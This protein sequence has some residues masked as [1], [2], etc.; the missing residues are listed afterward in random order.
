MKITKSQLE[1]IIKE[2]LKEGIFGSSPSRDRKLGPRS[3]SDR[4]HATGPL[5]TKKHAELILALL[6]NL[7]DDIMGFADVETRQRLLPGLYRT[8][9]SLRDWI[10]ELDKEQY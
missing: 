8:R 9:T 1:K 7:Y 3:L 2:E 10:Q 6:E 4:E 5:A